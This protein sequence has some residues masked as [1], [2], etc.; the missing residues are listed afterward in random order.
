MMRFRKPARNGMQLGQHNIPIS[1]LFQHL[2]IA[3]NPGT[4]KSTVIR[5][6]LRQ[7]QHLE[8]PGHS[9]RHRG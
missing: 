6:V 8:A 1:K 3:G 4:G 2:M 5:Q 9:N 7:I